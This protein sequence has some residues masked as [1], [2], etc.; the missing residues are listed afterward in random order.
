M[1]ENREK[2]CAHV[3]LRGKQ[4]QKISKQV[5]THVRTGLRWG[6]KDGE[7]GWRCKCSCSLMRDQ[8]EES[9]KRATAHWQLRRAV[10][11]SYVSTTV[12]YCAEQSL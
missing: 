4:N 8:E 1:V 9:C 2:W 3:N 11:S 12:V 7:T 10:L 5:Q 6:R